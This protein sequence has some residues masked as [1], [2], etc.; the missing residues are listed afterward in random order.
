MGNPL[1]C[2]WASNKC[3]R[4]ANLERLTSLL[5]AYSNDDPSVIPEV[6]AWSL[7]AVLQSQNTRHAHAR[8]TPLTQL[9]QRGVKLLFPQDS[10][11]L[12]H[13]L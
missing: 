3:A 4:Y 6:S 1:E 13:F 7:V 11:G 5:P 9:T 12:T 10:H 8:H 2:L